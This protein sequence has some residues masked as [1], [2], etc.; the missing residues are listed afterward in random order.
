M[1]KLIDEDLLE[2]VRRT[3]EADTGSGSLPSP[4]RCW[5]IQPFGGEIWGENCGRIASGSSRDWAGQ[6]C[7]P[8]SRN[9]RPFRGRTDGPLPRTPLLCQAIN[10]IIEKH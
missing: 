1:E 8:L 2:W 7:P 3:E 10:Q 9:A 6:E 5:P 4:W